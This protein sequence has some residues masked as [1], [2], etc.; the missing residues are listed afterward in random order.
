MGPRNALA[1][2]CEKVGLKSRWRARTLGPSAPDTN[3]NDDPSWQRATAEAL[4]ATRAEVTLAAKAG[5]ARAAAVPRGRAASLRKSRMRSRAATALTFP[6]G[7]K[8]M[9]WWRRGDRV[10]TS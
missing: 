5:G 3:S 1:A 10:A 7:D 2:D 8:E 9:M 6:R 4:P